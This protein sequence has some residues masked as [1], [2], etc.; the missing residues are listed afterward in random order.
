MLL[1]TLVY[2]I[3]VG[4]VQMVKVP[5]QQSDVTSFLDCVG[6]FTTLYDFVVED[7]GWINVGPKLCRDPNED[8][9]ARLFNCMDVTRLLVSLGYNPDKNLTMDLV[10]MTFDEV[11]RLG[12]SSQ[13]PDPT[14]LNLDVPN[15]N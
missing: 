11:A 14:A 13:E 8:D 2:V 3:T 7:D 9:D 12:G 1:L 15:T 5:L 10:D 6:N 4:A